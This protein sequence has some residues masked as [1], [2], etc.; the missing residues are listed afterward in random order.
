MILE[1]VGWRDPNMVPIRAFYGDDL[2]VNYCGKLA[3]DHHP[4]VRT[5]PCTIMVQQ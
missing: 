4:Q 1:M 5:S 2:K 3:T